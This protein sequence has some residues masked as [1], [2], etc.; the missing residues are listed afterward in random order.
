MRSLRT[1]T[2]VLVLLF[3]GTTAQAQ[4]V[5]RLG[6]DPVT[7]QTYA[8]CRMQ[9]FSEDNLSV[10]DSLFRE[11][12]R[13][14]SWRL[15][16]LALSLEFPVRFAQGDYAR[17]DS[18]ISAIKDLASERKEARSFY[19]ATMHEYCEF[20]V[21]LGRASDAMLEARAMERTA[22]RESRPLGRMYAYRIIALIQSY[23]SN[24]WLAIR[25]FEKA[26][27]F[28]ADASQEQDLPNM[29]ILIAQECIK[30]RDFRAAQHW[31]SLAS[32]Y[33]EFFPSVR[34]KLQMTDAYRAYAQGDADAFRSIYSALQDNPLYAVQ[35]D[36]DTRARLDICYYITLRRFDEALRASDALSTPIGRY[37]VKHG[38]YAARGEWEDAYG[39][40]GKL[41]TEKDSVYIKVQNEDL[42]ILDAEMNNAQLRE[43]AQ[44]LKAQNQMTIMIGFLVMFAIAFLAILLSQWQLRQ[45]LDEMR[46][47]NSQNLSARR[48]FQKAME[49]K[50]SE[51]AYK[52]KIMQNRTTNVLTNY[53][54]ILNL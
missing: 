2:L 16:C 51:N 33:S 17:M 30:M 23:R 39:Q 4:I 15:Q 53:E 1:A 47:K 41:M 11:G 3:C 44:R 43:E 27:K 25:N 8:G 42:A 48:A 38:I 24:S 32:T 31:C 28:A 40:L 26:V 20:L 21:R 50:E 29:Y 45:N 35:A 37:D 49:A 19:Y 13:L 46:R 36:S 6:V 52:I 22:S 5:N 9:Q 10:A 12:T 34:L 14:G 18:A 7:W 54:D